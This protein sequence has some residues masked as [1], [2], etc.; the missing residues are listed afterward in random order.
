MPTIKDVAREAG[1]SIATV[2]YVLNNKVEAVSEDTR[3]LVWEAIERIGY[4]PNITARNLRASQSRLIG[5]AWHEVPRDQVNTVL[6]RFTYF[7]AQSAEAAGYHILTFTFPPHDPLPVYDDLIRTRRVD[8]FVVSGT[9]RDDSRIAYLLDR[10]VPFVSFGRA[11]PTWMHTWVDTD[12]AA[13]MRLAVQHLVELGHKRISF[14]G[15][16]PPSLAGEDRESG[17]REGLTATDCEAGPIWHGENSEESGRV[18]LRRWLALPPAA[19]PTAVL[20]VSDLMAIGLLNEAERYGVEIGRELSVVGFDDAPASQ[21]LRPALTTLRQPIPDIAQAVIS[22][23]EGQ[24][25]KTAGA[26]ERR[27][28]EP[29]LVARKSS[30]P[31]PVPVSR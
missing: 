29:E 5:Y 2:S 11:N 9:R 12:G 4:T 13:G 10:D 17:F 20:A 22:L 6:D 8:G 14:L 23:L 24:L 26:P 19:R 31:A 16:P 1:V 25:N 21:Y 3:R 28:F 27:L 30:G 18:A 15:W 7:L